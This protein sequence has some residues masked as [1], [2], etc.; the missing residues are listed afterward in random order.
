MSY[1]GGGAGGVGGRGIGIG[2]RFI[3]LFS[4]NISKIYIF[5]KGRGCGE[6]ERVEF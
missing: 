1:R 2:V 6:G 5:G 4:K 3:D